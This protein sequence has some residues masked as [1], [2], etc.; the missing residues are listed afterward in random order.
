MVF[1]NRQMKKSFFLLISFLYLTLSAF[2]QAKRPTIMIVPSDNWCF[3]NG[4]IEEVDNEGIK[5]RRPNYARAMMENSDLGNVITKIN[6]L[7]GDRGFPL[8]TLDEA[9]KTVKQNAA[10]M[11][12]MQSKTSGAEVNQ[13]AYDQLMNVVKSDIIIKL[14]WTLT[15]SGFNKSIQINIE[16][17]DAYTGESIASQNPP[18]EPSSTADIPTMLSVTV[19]SVIDNFN[20]R[21]Q[22]YFDNLFA[23]GRKITVR[24]NKF[25][26][27]DGDFESEFEYNGST[28][29]LNT[30]IDD[31][32]SKNTVKGR[33]NNT[34][35]TENVM[36]FKQVRIPMFNEKGKAIDAK[37]FVKPLQKMLQGAPFN[38]PTK[39]VPKG[40][41]QAWLILGEK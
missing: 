13:G 38:I 24:L 40:L 16:A 31:W 28:D 29:E 12:L 19:L 6:G 30:I 26:S 39:L 9:L 11:M 5:E 23:D 22:T 10:E 25:S 3:Q 32:F 14:G 20:S 7:M 21:L 36:N 41:G 1:K 2:A 34:G 15:K 37:D 17:V 33:F 8:E 27:W 35:S 18:G 4:F